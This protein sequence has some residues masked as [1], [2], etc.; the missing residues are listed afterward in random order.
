MK[1][2]IGTWQDIADILN[3]ELQ[4]EYTESKFRKQ[5]QSFQKIFE[6]NENK[7]FND[8]HYLQSI[9]EQRHALEKERI[10]LREEKNELH[11]YLKNIANFE[12]QKDYLEELIKGGGELSFYPDPPSKIESNNDLLAILSDLHIGQTFRSAF[13]EFD[14]EIAAKRMNKYLNHII[15]IG[16]DHKSERCYLSLQGD[17]ISNN[18]HKTLAIT[19]R[20]NVIEQL[21]LSSELVSLFI[22][23]LSRHFQE[24]IV[25]SVSGNHSRI[26]IKKDAL[27]GERLDD[28]IEW[29]AKAKLSHIPNITFI[30][31]KIHSSISNF[32]I[33]GLTYCNVH[34]DYDD[35][36][37]KGLNR[38]IT[39]LGFVPYCVTYGHKH[40]CAMQDINGVRLVRSG[41]FAG[42]GCDYTISKRY[43]GKPSQMVCICTEE[44]IT[45]LHPIILN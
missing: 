3:S 13:G 24:V 45:S 25:T 11:G 26:D 6:A 16:E 34:G 12:A 28:L 40:S 7:I 18:I 31:E 8:A 23:G 15:R 20:E 37:E 30:E 14:S 19:N 35:F 29:Y 27:M 38:L 17:M 21:K 9:R 4:T 22:Y 5:I 33:R 10:K 39:L 41:S 1:D 42:C 32:T 44:G 36:S 43:A 2:E